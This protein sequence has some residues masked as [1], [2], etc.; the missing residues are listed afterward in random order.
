MDHLLP[1][2]RAGEVDGR[3]RTHYLESGPSDGEPVVFVHGNLSTGRFFEHLMPGAPERWR[4]LAP[5]MRGFGRSEPAPIDATRGLGDWAD[6]LVGFLDALG[7]DRP[8]HLVGWSTAGAAIALAARARTVASLT[9][10]DPVSPY[11]FGGVFRDGSPCWPDVAGSGAGV[12]N[13]EFV[14]RLRERDRSADSPLSPRNV[15][16]AT[17]WAAGHREPPDREDILVDEI[18]LTTI[19][20]DGYP[21]DAQASEHWPGAAPGTRG[22]LNALSPKYCDWSWL[23]TLNPLPPVLWT[24][25]ADDLV[26]ADGS[27]LELGTL[28]AA[29]TV[30]GWPGPDVFPPQPMVAQ[31]RDVLEAYRA[32]GGRAEIEIFTGSGHGPHVDAAE[33]WSATFFAFL[34]STMR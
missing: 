24:H 17:Y 16:N 1:G 4:L 2:V 3:I 8:A 23:P 27:A 34:E 33:R 19:S 28:G 18:L 31:I 5:D 30:P 26:V 9:F 20:D 15:M 10:L 13:P 14:Q 12:A 32:A 7:V 29:G 21:G 25:G 6:D 11:G 22:L